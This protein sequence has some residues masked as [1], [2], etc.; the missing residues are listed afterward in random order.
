MLA[1]SFPVWAALLSLYSQEELGPR[2][3]RWVTFMSQI[4][5][6]TLDNRLWLFFP[7]V[8][9]ILHPKPKR[10]IFGSFLLGH[11]EGFSLV[12][13]WPP[14][15]KTL[16]LSL[17]TVSPTLPSPARFTLGSVFKA[18]GQKGLLNFISCRG[19]SVPDSAKMLQPE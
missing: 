15:Y 8:G 11:I 10:K 4:F 9:K 17:A 3:K 13:T 6:C 19:V 1:G 2:Q 7:E 18:S 12:F 5:L 14:V 16:P